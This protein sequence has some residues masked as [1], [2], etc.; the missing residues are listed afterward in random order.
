MAKARATIGQNQVFHSIT[1]A[2][3]CTSSDSALVEVYPIPL[4]TLIIAPEEG[5]EPLEVSFS[6]QAEDSIRWQ[7]GADE[8]I[9]STS[10][11]T[12]LQ[13]GAYTLTLE[14]FNT[15]G[16]RILIDT[17]LVVHPKPVAQFS[18]SPDEVYLDDPTYYF[19]DESYDN[20][21][22]W[23]WS[24]GDGSGAVDQNP[25][26][27]YGLGGEYLVTLYVEDINDCMDSTDMT[28]AVRDNLVVFI[29]TS[30]SPDNEDNLN[31]VFKVSGVG[32]TNVRCQIYNRWGEKLLDEE[33]FSSWD[34]TYMG[35]KVQ[36][37]IYIYQMTFTDYKNV[38]HFKNGTIQVIR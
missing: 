30:F 19:T 34:G 24:F 25:I 5:C 29:P 15:D 32:F 20:I 14:V 21:I 36:S 11:T 33:D 1:N 16:C 23:N 2:N 38:R 37:G 18:H 3:G 27:T 7:L 31:D 26:H 4:N 12:T 28:V 6:T 9:D 17:P 13:A 8:Y 10:V 22:G 35:E